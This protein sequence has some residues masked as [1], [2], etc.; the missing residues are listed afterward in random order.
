MSETVG[1]LNSSE[2]SISKC[3]QSDVKRPTQTRIQLQP[4]SVVLDDVSKIKSGSVVASVDGV[5]YRKRKKTRRGKSKRRRLKPYTRLS[6]Q[7]RSDQDDKESNK[8]TNNIR[9]K[10][11]LCR[12]PVAPYNTTQFL[13]DDHNDLQDLDVQLKAVKTNTDGSKSNLPV[14]H[15]QSR[16]RDSSFSVDS[17]D[18]FYSSPEDEGDFL[19][20]E[21]SNTYEDLHAERLNSLPKAQLIQEYLQLEEKVDTLEKKLKK[22]NSDAEN[23]PRDSN[24]EKLTSREGE[25][26]LDNEASQKIQNLKQEVERLFVENEQLRRENERLRYMAGQSAPSGSSVDSESDSTA[27]S[28]SSSSSSS[29]SGSDSSGEQSGHDNTQDRTSSAKCEEIK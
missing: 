2:S 16:A 8:R 19:S 23:E 5:R 29:S 20:K 6:W 13:M 25:G 21:F 11:F 26:N 15:R 14:L 22:S 7:D 27:S 9:A 17:D 28:C 10:M 18:D 4:S 1:P 3:E 24:C 12:Q